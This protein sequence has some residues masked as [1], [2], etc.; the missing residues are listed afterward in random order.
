MPIYDYGTLY[1]QEAKA[2]SLTVTLRIIYAPGNA[3]LV[4]NTTQF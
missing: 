2:A 1:V 4:E 3:Q